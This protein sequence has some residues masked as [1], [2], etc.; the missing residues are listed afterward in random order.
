MYLG[1]IAL[2]WM[3]SAMAPSSSQKAASDPWLTKPVDERTFRT[4]LDF[5]RYDAQLPFNMRVL[6]TEGSVPG[7]RIEHLVFDSTPGAQV[8]ARLYRPQEIRPNQPSAILLHGGAPSRQG[9]TEH[10]A[11]RAVSRAG[12]LERVSRSTCCTSGTA[13][14][15]C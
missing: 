8:H 5:F 3:T 12:R 2:L 1:L 11:Q 10:N 9:R 7:I 4:Y 13:A 14:R 6:D 15:T